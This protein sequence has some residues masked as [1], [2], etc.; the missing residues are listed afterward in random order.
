MWSERK[1]AMDA[2]NDALQ[3]EAR[4][5]YEGFELIEEIIQMMHDASRP[6]SFLTV[7]GLVLLKGRNLA[8]G[9]FSLA[10][11]GLAQ[12]SGALLR[13]TIECIELLEYFRKDP[14]RIK[15]AIENKLPSAGIIAKKI[16][17]SFKDLR[18]YLSSN[19]SH[20]SLTPGAMLHL[21]DGRDGDVKLKQPYTERVLRRNL[22]DLFLV[23]LLLSSGGTK[24]LD[25]CGC[26]SR[27]ISGRFHP[28]REKGLKVVVPQL[29][30]FA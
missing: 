18:A 15:E 30:D 11:E 4:L 23:I 12:E 2:L 9:M 1:K 24:C 28:W 20:F 7:C 29:K 19:A 5:I 13:P 16:D 27:P 17:G 8:Q 22:R 26:L 3:E 14:K 10:L 21:I 25:V 6:T